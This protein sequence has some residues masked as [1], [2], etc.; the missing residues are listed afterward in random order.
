MRLTLHWTL[1]SAS[2][3]SR[4][5]DSSEVPAMRVL[6]GY[7]EQGVPAIS[8]ARHLPD[9]F[10]PIHWTVEAVDANGRPTHFESMPFQRPVHADGPG[11][12]WTTYFTWPTSSRTGRRVNWL[13][14]PVADYQWRPGRADAGGFVQQALGG[15]KPTA[16]QPVVD[17]RAMVSLS[18]AR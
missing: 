6:Q 2:Q 13:E 14:L 10:V 11:T 5:Y 1:H 18:G 4:E 7:L 17:L 8:Q 15:W 9:G 3:W 12:D 16:G